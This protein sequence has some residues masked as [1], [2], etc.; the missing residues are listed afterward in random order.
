M[1][2]SFIFFTLIL[3]SLSASSEDCLFPNSLKDN[4]F[5]S[6][7]VPVEYCFS[8]LQ[9]N[10]KY[11]LHISYAAQFPSLFLMQL[12]SFDNTVHSSR[13]RRLSTQSSFT[14]SP[15][16]I[17]DTNNDAKIIHSS[18]TKPFDASNV[19]VMLMAV[20]TSPFTNMTSYDGVLF[21][22]SLD[23]MLFGIIPRSFKHLIS[24]IIFL[25]IF[26]FASGL[27]LAFSPMSPF[28]FFEFV[29][30]GSTLK[31]KRH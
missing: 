7:K 26:G 15:K 28:N 4:Q 23:E 30:P 9:K 6:F 10:A 3:R 2:L 11:E 21:T 24:V 1:G 18:L 13:G 12:Y 25:L 16:L 17:F 27:W 14:D 5:I 19:K 29:S 22:I 20:P 8:N 31:E